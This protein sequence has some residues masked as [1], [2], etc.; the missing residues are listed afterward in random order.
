VVWCDAGLWSGS[1][2]ADVCWAWSLGTKIQ[3]V[4]AYTGSTAATA[5]WITASESGYDSMGRVISLTDVA[6]HT[7]TTAYTPSASAAA[8]SG[9]MTSATMTNPLGWTSSATVDPAWGEQ[10]G[11]V[12]ANGSTTT[13]TYD[14]L[15]RRTAVWYPNHPKS[16]NPNQ[17]NAAYTYTL[18]QTSANVVKTD[19]IVATSVL[20]E[21]DLY[22]GLGRLVQSQTPAEGGGAKISDNWYDTQGR[23]WVVNNP[24]WAAANASSTPFIPSTESQIPS[25]TITHYDS[26]GRTTA[27]ILDSFGSERYRTSNT[28]PGVDRVDTTPPTGGTPTSVFTDSRGNKTELIQYLASTVSGTATTET[29]NYSY[30]ASAHMTGMTDP[31]S[32]HWSWGYDVLGRQVTASDPDTGTTTSNF[33]DSGNLTSTTD[34]RGITLDYEYDDLNRKTSQ[35][36]QVAGGDAL[37]TAWKYDTVK[38]GQLTSSSSYVG[39]TPTTNGL[40]YTTTVLG[41]DAQYNPTSSKVSIP[42][43]APAFAGTSYTTQYGYAIDGSLITVVYPAMGGL[44]SERLH[45]GYDAFGLLSN[46]GAYDLA[47]YDPLG[48]I[49][50]DHSNATQDLYRGY[51]YD[52]AN[53]RLLSIA[54]STQAAGTSTNQQSTNY[55]YDDAGR[56]TSAKTAS[57][58]SAT[59]TQC[60]KYDYLADLTQ[61]FTP[62]SGS[63]AAAPTAAG[64]GGPAP[65]WIDYGVSVATGNR[66]S[67]TNHQVSGTTTAATYSYPAPSAAHPHAVSQ[68]DTTGGSSTTTSYQYDAAGNTTDRGTGTVTWNAIGKPATVSQGTTTQSDV[69]NSDDD[70]LLQTDTVSGATL[71]LGPTELHIA[72]G[73]S[74]VTATRTYTRGTTPVAERSTRSGSA[75]LTWLLA[76]Q[77]GTVTAQLADSSGTLTARRQDPYGQ[78]R[79]GTPDAWDDGHGFLNATA[80]AGTGLSQLGARQYD[81]ALGRFISVDSVLAPDNPQQNNGYSYSANDPVTMSDPSGLC[82]GAGSDSMVTR[83]NCVGMG[84]SNTVPKKPATTKKAPTAAGKAQSPA[85]KKGSAKATSS[86]V[87][88]KSTRSARN[89]NERK[90]EDGSD[91]EDD[92]P[93]IADKIG[94][95]I[96]DT[97]DAIHKAKRELKLRG[98]GQRKNPDVEIEINSGNIRIKGG[99]G[100]VEGNLDDYLSG[101]NFSRVGVQVPAINWGAVLQGIGVGALAVGVIGVIIIAAPLEAATS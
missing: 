2:S 16:A 17:P 22:D 9:P 70:L 29:T 67:T 5:Q 27:T 28:Y 89:L 64:L 100:E 88:A 90:S 19:S 76:D 39:S 49:S 66:L 91:W 18:S 68:V 53:G 69:Y 14:A 59:D 13:A 75:V 87:V 1:A 11:V 65:Y 24:Y 40:A 34:A 46:V 95:S 7:S 61:A 12:D 78:A 8:G 98:V 94:R 86:G 84:V 58:S 72:A 96:R 4:K 74:T 15:G 79:S 93:R 62:A 37:L 85:A 23:T 42:T 26:A 35:S 25:E 82:A 57:D 38:K 31:G 63:C 71:F 33:D 30:D 101:N 6:G 44:S 56:I 20:S 77:Q 73:S 36:Q 47:T 52:Q 3:T 99:P 41:Y 10:T 60:F 92:V 43:G 97:K 55:A 81:A 51:G 54:N 21:Y 80:S 32:A 83:T 50:Q 48:Q 45:Y